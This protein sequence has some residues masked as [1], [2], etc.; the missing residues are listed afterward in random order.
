VA[1]GQ[2]QPKTIQKLKNMTENKT[3]TNEFDLIGKNGIIH[4]PGIKAEITYT[5]EKILHWKTTDDAGVVASAE[6]AIDYR[7]LTDNLHFLNWIEKDG[8]TVSQIIDTQAGTVKAFW[9]FNDDTSERG[10]RTSKFV[11]GKFEYN[12]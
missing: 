7:Q 10:K 5:S 12:N 8:W 1:S 4:F 3:T 6:E 9:S 11:E 2:P